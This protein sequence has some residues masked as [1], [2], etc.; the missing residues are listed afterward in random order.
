MI[1]IIINAD[2]FGRSIERNKAIDD[3]FKQGFIRSAGLIVTGKYLEDATCLM[4]SGRYVE[5]IHLHL[6]LSTSLRD[7]NP[8]DR[9]LTEAMRK[10]SYFCKD[11]MFKKYSGLPHRFSDIRKWKIVYNELVAQYKKFIEVTDGKADYKHVDFHLWYN[12]T[13]P[14]AIALNL[15][16]IRY[17][18]K[19]VRYISLHQMKSMRFKLLR[20]VSW[21]P[22]VKYIP[23]TNIDYY[24]TKKE[25]IDKYPI[26]E[27]Y[28]HP[29][30]K[31]SVLLDDSPSYL[32]HDRQ[33]MLKQ[34][35][36]LRELKDVYFVS[37]KEPF[38]HM[39]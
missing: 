20:F 19:S 30:Y 26:M 35:H 21:N 4:N 17:N 28:C 36:D 39:A 31:D 2:D 37:W 24:L 9:P 15:F 34:I 33:P 22:R 3:S 8:E 23:A 1:R 38:I 6:N 13:W 11:G 25:I 10:D 27:L 32:K 7:G 5:N 29:N 14:V 12:L 16:T 18:I